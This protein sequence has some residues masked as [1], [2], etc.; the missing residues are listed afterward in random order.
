MV[1]YST[2]S[3]YSSSTSASTAYSSSAGSSGSSKAIYARS[4]GPC[5]HRGCA[6]C[7]NYN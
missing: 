3:G 7:P 6:T 1:S 5:C 2:S 4:S